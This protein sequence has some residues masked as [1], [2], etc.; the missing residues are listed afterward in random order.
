MEGYRAK[1]LVVDDEQS[2]LEVMEK[3]LS[4]E[5]YAVVTAKQASIALNTLRRQKFDLVIT[6]LRMP[7]V[8]GLELLRAIRKDNTSIPVILLTAYGTVE[9]AVEAMKLGA[10]DFLSKPIKREVLLK[11]IQ[12]TLG[13]KFTETDGR[14]RMQFIGAHPDILQIKKTVRLLARTN[15]TVLIEGESGSGKEIIAKSIHQESNR[16]GR[17]ITVNCGAIP[18][19]LLESELFGYEKGAFTG[20]V[21]NKVGLFEAADRGTI[22]LDEIGEMPNQLQVKLL[23]TL[24]DNTFFRI[25]S[26]EPRKVDVRVV[27]A[28]NADLRKKIADGLFREDLYYRLNVVS[29]FVPALRNRKED[30]RLLA[31]YFLALA[32]ESY[33]RPDVYFSPQAYEAME[34]HPWDGNVRELRNT[35]ERTV[36]LLEGNEITPKDLGVLAKPDDNKILSQELE[37]RFPLGTKL[38]EVEMEMI[39]KTL[40]FTNG[41]KAKAAELLGINQRTIYRKISDPHAES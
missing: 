25:G 26:T 12:D 39:R 32:K 38:R 16:E 7:G 24:Q 17:L 29:I 2:N 40:E 19:S 5:A 41:D 21:G 3:I 35:I 15:A 4:K 27:A 10:V 20:A 37:F 14:S 8:S 30:I 1:I 18:D 9:D 6:D 13:R 33:S 11:A 36:V 22:F 31:D 23:R 34:F 28:T